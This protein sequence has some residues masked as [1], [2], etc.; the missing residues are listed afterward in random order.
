MEK[1]Y[2]K[3]IFKASGLPV[4][5]YVVLRERDW[6]AADPEGK[7]VQDA[8]AELG[9]PVFVKPA[10]GGSSI[11]TSKAADLASLHE[12]IE[13]ARRYDPKVLVEKAIE[14]REIEC[15]DGFHIVGRVLRGQFAEDD[16]LEQRIYAKSIRAV[17]GDAG[18]LARRVDSGNGGRA[19]LIGLN[20]AHPIMHA[21]GDRHRFV[22]R[23]DAGGIEGEFADLRQ[24]F[25]DFLLAEVAKIQ[26]DATVDATAFIDLGL[27]GA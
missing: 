5:P 1:F 21:R 20:A 19:V 24:P 7:R 9:W 12:A 17:H 13:T 26:E 16:R 10:R 4:G 27:L 23:V 8:I 15:A 14:G 22:D 25:H 11:G 2:M 3:M 6:P 18:A